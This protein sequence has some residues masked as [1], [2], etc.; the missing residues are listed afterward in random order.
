MANGG[1]INYNVRFNA[2]T[3]GLNRPIQE[4]QKIQESLKAVQ[5]INI[6]LATAGKASEEIQ[7]IIQGNRG[8]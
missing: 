6:Q 3:S 2:D 7:Q 8:K 1:N 4:L 5:K